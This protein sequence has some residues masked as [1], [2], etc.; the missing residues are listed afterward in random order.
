MMPSETAPF[1]SISDKIRVLPL[2]HGSGDFAQVVRQKMLNESFDCLAVCI[3]PSFKDSVEY[4]VSL[5]PH[6]TLAALEEDVH[7]DKP[8]YSYIPID[9]CQPVIMGIRIA[10]E[11]NIPC[12]YID[13]EVSDF[14]QMQTILPDA[15]ALKKVSIERFSAA[16][17]P[18]IP[19]PQQG[20]QQEKRIRWMSFQLHCLELQFN[21]IL[22]LCSVLDWP[23]VKDSY[24][25]RLSYEDHEV[26]TQTPR[27]YS[28][29]E[30]SLYFVLGELSYITYLYEKRR[31][32]L[33]SDTYLS[34]DGVKEVV[35][36][37]RNRWIKKHELKYHSLTP[38]VLN[39]FMKYVR[40][41]TL[42]ERRMT[43]DIYTLVTAAK[44]IGG[45]G[46]AISLME[47]ACTYPYQRD[48]N[49]LQQV[50]MGI[51]KGELP[52]SGVVQMK[53]RLSGTAISWRKLHLKPKP[54]IKK[55][56]LWKYLWDP[57]GQCSWPVEDQK[58]E[59]FNL[60]V[61]EQAK[62]L[63]GA[64]LVRTEKFTTSIKDGIDIR[65]TL[66]H[67]YEGDIYVKEIP[68]TRGNVEVIVLI[69]EMN[70]D[71][72][73][74]N[75]QQ[76]WYAEHKVES[77]LCFYATPYLDNM[78]G[79]GVA[80][81]TY[82]GLFLLFPPRYIANIWQDHRFDFA[83][84]LEER[85][86]AAAFFYSKEKHVAIISPKHPS[87]SWRRLARQYKKSLVYIPLQRFS[88]QTIEKI[89]RFHILNGKHVRSYAARFISDF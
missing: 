12:A 66:R 83:K 64:D 24:N 77:T 58:I 80:E 22:F 8:I 32:E 60:H 69:F 21:K 42:L 47:T 57:F 45:D 79:P 62:T 16:I 43:P 35:I 6:I 5:L 61:R 38:Q 14:E 11:E 39:I 40:N 7:P 63:I 29:K 74:Y 10:L 73:K 88:Q 36:E 70:P 67:W 82:G 65:D 13:R 9:P 20:S 86:L 81:S 28:V 89:R 1:L 34:I 48:K 19:Q 4:G 3:P 76:T 50:L 75:W 68:P 49:N 52:E 23:W 17:L 18:T 33:A 44:Q 53:N 51:E 71:P 59:S 87:L 55:Q 85:L 41:L 30:N 15:Y 37:A 2:I 54:E 26:F 27:L 78:I 72:N 46:F 31:Q 84:T 25:Q 56:K